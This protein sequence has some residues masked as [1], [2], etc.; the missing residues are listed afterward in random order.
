MFGFSHITRKAR[1]WR[2]HQ[3]RAAMESVLMD[4]PLELQKDIGWPGPADLPSLSSAQAD[5]HARPM[6]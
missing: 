6:L 4:L 1:Q 3:K 2:A 5:I